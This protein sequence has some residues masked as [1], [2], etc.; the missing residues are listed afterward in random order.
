VRAT[1]PFKYLRSI[2]KSGAELLNGK[3]KVIR[4]AVSNMKP[5]RPPIEGEVEVE[6]K[7]HDGS[8]DSSS[9]GW[10]STDTSGE[11]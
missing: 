4:A 8:D 10:I 11:D 6:E 5:F 3:G 9:D 2:N 7:D 1:G